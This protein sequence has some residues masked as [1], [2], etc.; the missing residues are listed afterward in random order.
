MINKAYKVFNKRTLKVEESTHVVFDEYNH[1]LPRN[2]DD[3]DNVDIVNKMDELGINNKVESKDS[4]EGTSHGHQDA[5][6][7]Q[8]D[9]PKDWR[10]AKDHLKEQIIG[11]VSKGV[12]IKSSAYLDIGNVAFVSQIEPRNVDDALNDEHWC[13]AM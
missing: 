12:T 2:Y 10:F 6:Q 1:S 8:V 9:L 5:Q 3:D 13:V 4:N 7:Q 11:D